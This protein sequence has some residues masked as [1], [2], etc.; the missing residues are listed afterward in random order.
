MPEVPCGI[1][2]EV[3]DALDKNSL[4]RLVAGVDAQPRRMTTAEVAALGDPFATLLLAKGKIPRNGEQLLN[5]IKAAVPKGDPLKRQRSFL[6]GEGSQLARTKESAGVERA[7]R[8]VV[9]L[10]AGPNGPDVFLSAFDPKQPG[11]IE[12]MA[13]DHRTGGFNYYR[14]TG[15]ESLWMFAGN[16]H[17][18][19]RDGSRGNG[20][21]ESHPSGSLLMKELKTPWV[22]WHSP[23][24]LVADDVFPKNDAR[25]RHPWFTDKDPNGGLAFE[26]EAARPAMARWANVRFRKLRRRGGAVAAPDQIMEQILGT[27][28]VNLTTTHVE[29]RA[30]RPDDQLDLPVTFFVDSD[31]LVDVLGLEAPPSFE[32][33]GEIYAKCLQKFDVHM[34]DKHGFTPKGDAHFCFLVP[35]RA[36]EDQVVLREA[37][38]IGLIGKRLAACLLMVDPW[39]PVFSERRSA[40]LAHV[41][42]TAT[43]KDGK[44]TFSREMAGAILRAAKTAP[45]GSPEE[46]FATRWNAG[47]KFAR[48]FDKILR[49]YYKAVT[50]KL[51]TQAGFEP[52][53]KLAE[54]R[55]RRFGGMRISEFPLLLPQSHIEPAPRRMQSDGTVSEG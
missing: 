7:I 12:V 38:E 35:E 52:Y 42:K 23:D 54:E 26:T 14:S 40:L 20:P 48:E 24:A 11:G 47:P 33:S 10:G 25:R 39:N 18:A 44:S 30:L 4:N 31:G 27:P 43:I 37:I 41:P 9:T 16:S 5:S 2:D 50:E 51:K 19:L 8:F 32:V 1:F 15:D 49:R 17:D 6:V 29:S 22:N 45:K 34:D 55:R 36:N 21:F 13:W 3:E 46:T 53:F 28:T